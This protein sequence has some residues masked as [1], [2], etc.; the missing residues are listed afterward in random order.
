MKAAIIIPK[1]DD[2]IEKTLPAELVSPSN[3]AFVR[4]II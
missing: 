3:A 4:L 1:T 2:Q